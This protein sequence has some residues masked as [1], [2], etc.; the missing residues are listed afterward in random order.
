MIGVKQNKQAIIWRIEGLQETPPELTML[1]N[2]ANLDLSYTQLVT[3][4]RTLGGFIQEYWGEQL[5]SLSA[6]GRTAMFYNEGGI[7]NSDTRESESYQNFIRLVNIYKN[8]GKDYY[9]E[10]LT[11]AKNINPDRIIAFGTV[12]MTYMEKQYQGYFESFNIKEMAEK[13]FNLEYDFTFKVTKTVGD[14]IV[15]SSNFIV[16]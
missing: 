1:I 7:T 4:N 11:L 15:K 14:F 9:S 8:N 12:V 10:R 6:T 3:E 2:P 5:T 13:P 16:E